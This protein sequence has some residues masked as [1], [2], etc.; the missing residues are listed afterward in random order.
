MIRRPI[1]NDQ[2]YQAALAAIEPFFD[3]QPAP[4]SPEAD[5]FDLLAL[6]IED[7]ERRVHPIPPPDPISAIRYMMELKGYTQSDLATLVGSR[8][9]A[10]DIL[11][12]KRGLSMQ[13]VRAL[14]EKWGVP[15]EGLVS[16][17]AT[18]A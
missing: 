1:R 4:G 11:L 14:H 2:D 8:Q 15:L 9:R 16:S 12:G 10:S 18:A 17:S 5:D 7:Y 3:N 13:M 6:L